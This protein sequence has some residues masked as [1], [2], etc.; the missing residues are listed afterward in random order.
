MVGIYVHTR[1][2]FFYFFNI[3]FWTS[4]GKVPNYA[5]NEITLIWRADSDSN[6]FRSFASLLH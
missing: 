5:S 2:R 6:R 1:N 4:C 3:I